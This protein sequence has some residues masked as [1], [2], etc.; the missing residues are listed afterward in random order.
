MTYQL[1]YPETE[2]FVCPADIINR[3][4][5]DWFTNKEGIKT[6]LS[7]LKKCGEYFERAI[8]VYTAQD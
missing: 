1:A 4:R 5:T 8:K 7:E 2:F 6:V 3:G